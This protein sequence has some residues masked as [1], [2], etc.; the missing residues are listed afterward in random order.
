MR[1][2]RRL[3]WLRCV[4]LTAAIVGAGAARAAAPVDDPRLARIRAWYAATE[5]GLAGYRVVRRDLAEFATQ[6][7]V[8]TAYLAGDTLAKLNGV[9]YEDRGRSTDDFYVRSDSVYFAS[10][11]V[12]TYS[13]SMMAG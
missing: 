9:Y 2:E 10:H 13:L 12:G 1:V 5:K 7:A 3:G 6:G 4:L 11:I 8:L